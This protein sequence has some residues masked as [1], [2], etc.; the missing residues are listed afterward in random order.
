MLEVRGLC[1]GYGRIQVLQDVSIAAQ[2][3]QITALIGPNGAGKT[4]LCRALS[5]VIKPSR[6]DIMLDGENLR[7][8][9]PHEITR[10]GLVQVPEG[11]HV[12]EQLSVHDNLLLAGRYGR[13]RGDERGD[14][15]A[16]CFEIFPR[17]VD[18]QR[19]AAGMLSG[20]EQ[21]MV[22]IARALMVKPSAL[23]LDEPSF[24]LAP[25]L[26]DE[27][28]DVL[29]RLAA[30]GMAIVLVEQNAEAALTM[31]ARACVM[32]G[33]KVVLEGSGTE[34]LAN[35]NVR[36]LYLGAPANSGWED[37]RPAT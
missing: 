24:G 6:G 18:K 4:T 23:V 35:E 28:F 3:G 2:A 14:L 12:F 36:K 9:R 13:G 19:D 20:G 10:R 21:Q 27:I 15:L 17:L 5:H 30:E 29:A 25:Q 11:R 26:V 37:T 33:G 16:R 8:R 22:S 32:Q 7:G 31:A 1:A 34:L